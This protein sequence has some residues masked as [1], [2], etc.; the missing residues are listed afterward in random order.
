MNVR[1]Q[2]KAVNSSLSGTLE[3]YRIWAK[4]HGLNYNE[5]IILYTLD[6]YGECT[7]KQISEYW[8][9][10]KQTTNGVLRDFENKGYIQVVSGARDKR[11]RIVSYTEAG[12][13][14]ASS[15]LDRLHEM[16]V[17]AMENLGADDCEQLVRCNQ[18]YFQ[19]LKNEIEKV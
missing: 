9:L 12:R 3:V 11:E 6:D 13:K 19:L 14:F 7:P 8:A 17:F 18:L 10:P 2:I 4:K 15:I 5:L 16:E 1:E